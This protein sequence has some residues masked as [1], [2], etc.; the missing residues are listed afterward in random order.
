MTDLNPQPK[1]M[2]DESMVRALSAQ[3]RPLAKTDPSNLPPMQSRESTLA[4]A[5]PKLWPPHQSNKPDQ[6][7][8]DSARPANLDTAFAEIDEELKFDW[9]ESLAVERVYSGIAEIVAA[10]FGLIGFVVLAL[11][12]I[13]R[14][15]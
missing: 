10:A 2:A 8:K 13:A 9:P 15:G 5:S 12:A 4:P 3:A 11:R 7:L 6:S 14:F 1:Q